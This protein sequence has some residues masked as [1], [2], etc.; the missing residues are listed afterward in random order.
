M[1]QEKKIS[2]KVLRELIGVKNFLD[3]IWLLAFIAIIFFYI[4][5]SYIANT[6]LTAGRY[7]LFMDERITFDGVRHIL[8]PV[9]VSDWILSVVHGGDH[10]YGRS[11]WN[12]ITIFAFIPEYFFGETGQIIAGRMAQV[13]ILLAAYG[14]ISVSFLRSWFM[15]F[16]LMAALLAMPCTAYYM[17]MPKPEPLQLLF[18]ALF[19]FFY[20]KNDFSLNSP[21]WV[22]LGMG[23]GTKITTLPLI[24]VFL[25]FAFTENYEK[26]IA[27]YFKDVLTSL[28]WILLGLC[29]AV[30]ILAG[31]VFGSIA[32]YVVV[33]KYMPELKRQFN[34]FYNYTVII[35][36]AALNVLIAVMLNRIGIK[37][38]LMTWVASTLLNTAHGSDRPE[39]WFGSWVQYFVTDWALA[40]SL[41][42]VVMIVLLGIYFLFS[43]F[44]NSSK[45]SWKINNKFPASVVLAGLI[46]YLSIMFTAHRLWGL[47]LFLGTIL[48]VAG[49][50]ILLQQDFDDFRYN[51]Q[52][53]RTKASSYLACTVF[54]LFVLI[55]SVWWFPKSI[56]NFSELA[57]RTNSDEYKSQYQSYIKITDF[58]AGYS[59]GCDKRLKV[60]ADPWLFLP[61]SNTYFEIKEFW[62]PF[63]QWADLPD[64]ILFSSKH[65]AKR[66]SIPKNA[67]Q[68]KSFILERDGY[69]MFVAN[70]NEKCSNTLC[71]RK[72]AD[73]P[74]GGEILTLVTQ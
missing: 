36:I 45:F 37:S 14:I 48:I 3:V 16:I 27:R 11:L 38:G 13:I 20:K 66:K 18:I 9:N 44:Y 73:L 46:L 21:Y 50:F 62:G 72:S 10:R 28:L 58:L 67:T 31:H 34:F 60:L 33:L 64:V 30:P 52:S 68:Y 12:S 69:N 56:S 54:P 63:T 49:L 7:V 17:S 2:D 4:G 55:V 24:P 57:N 23:F 39:I 1:V 53:L 42:T 15:R 47:Y 26:I 25:M 51:N 41:I 70:D 29:F 74:G 61:E 19:L 65:T 71:Y 32:L 40:P 8:H 35:M 6:D 22:L 59:K 5:L 43:F